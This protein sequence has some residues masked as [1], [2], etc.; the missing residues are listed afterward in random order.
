MSFNVVEHSALTRTEATLTRDC[1]PLSPEVEE[2]SSSDS[3]DDEGTVYAKDEPQRPDSRLSDTP[4]NTHTDNTLLS[5]E[6]LVP[7]VTIDYPSDN[8]S[9]HSASGQPDEDLAAIKAAAASQV[10]TALRNAIA[11][12]RADSS[13]CDSDEAPAAEIFEEAEFSKN[14]D[15]SDE[16]D[17]LSASSL[18]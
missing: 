17:A 5:V 14:L 4:S 8:D 16:A 11:I 9:N 15:E 3:S 6:S 1:Q 12:V 10:E 7:R 13:N 18:D 2:S